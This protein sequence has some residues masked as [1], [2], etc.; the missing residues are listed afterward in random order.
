MSDRRAQHESERRANARVGLAPCPFH[1]GWSP[2]LGRGWRHKPLSSSGNFSKKNGSLTASTSPVPPTRMGPAADRMLPNAVF[3]SNGS[4]GWRAAG[5]KFSR[6]CA[7]TGIGGG[8]Y[9]GTLHDPRWCRAGPGCTPPPRS[10]SPALGMG[11][12][13]RRSPHRA[14]VP[15]PLD[16]PGAESGNQGA[17]QRDYIRGTGVPSK[18][19]YG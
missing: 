18:P 5:E 17:T 2:P 9:S 14:G 11:L 8:T 4:L 19:E 3:E 6:R 16:T 1:K 15:S 13:I 10:V 12:A 7:E